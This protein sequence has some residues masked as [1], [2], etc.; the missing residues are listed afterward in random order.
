MTVRGGG[1]PGE[2]TVLIPLC[3]MGPPHRSLAADAHYCIMV[4]V[5]LA[6][7][8][9]RTRHYL[10]ARDAQA[11]LLSSSR[12]AKCAIVLGAIKDGALRWR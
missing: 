9:T 8:N 1:A 6:Q 2:T 12:P 5:F 10:A 4:W 3:R 11:P 7:P